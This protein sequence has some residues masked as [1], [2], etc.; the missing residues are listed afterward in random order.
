M[1]SKLFGQYIKSER[2]SEKGQ[3]DT[4]N[5]C[6]SAEVNFINQLFGI[7]SKCAYSLKNRLFFYSRFCGITF[8]LNIQ[9]FCNGTQPT[10]IIVG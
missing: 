1:F 2:V 9:I 7:A 8:C 5:R 10:Y 4:L 6:V 3:V